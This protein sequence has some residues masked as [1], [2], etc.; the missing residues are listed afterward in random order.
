[1]KYLTKALWSLVF[2]LPAV[3]F[4]SYHPIIRLGSNESMNF[5]LSL[6]LIWLVI[7]DVLAFVVMIWQGYELRKNNRGQNEKTNKKSEKTHQ[8]SANHIPKTAKLPRTSW[9]INF[10]GIS[11]RKIFLLALFPL[12]ATISIFWSM[13]PVRA[14]LT[15]GII[16]LVFFAVFALI[17][18]LPLIEPIKNFSRK[19]IKAILIPSMAVCGFCWLQCFLDIMGVGREQSLLC[20][21]CVSDMFGF[22]HPSGFAI[23]PQFMGNLLLAPTLLAIYLAVFP[24][25]YSSNKPF[26]WAAAAI[27]SSTLFI[28]F[29]RGAIY[30]YLVALAIMF[31]FAIVQHKSHP[32]T[33]KPSKSPQVSGASRSAANIYPK[34]HSQTISCPKSNFITQPSATDAQRGPR[35]CLLVLVSTITFIFAL[36]MQG[37]FAELGPTNTSFSTAITRSVHHLSLGLI[38]LRPAKTSQDYQ[39]TH[40]S[41]QN[42]QNSSSNNPQTSNLDSQNTPESTSE[43]SESPVDS[44]P[45]SDQAQ[46][47]TSLNEPTEGQNQPVFDGYVAESTNVRLNLN[48]IAFETWLSAPGHPAAFWIGY[49]CHTPG[50]PC[51]SSIQV[52]PTSVLFGVGLGG[53]GTAM[54][55]AHPD[56]IASPKEIVQNQTFSLLLELGAVGIFLAHL[57]LV[58]A[59]L[60][61]LLPWWFVDGKAGKKRPSSQ[62][63]GQ[64]I[65]RRTISKLREN[66]FW[67]SPALPL[68]LSLVIAYIVTLN[69]FSGLPNALQIYLMPPLLLI[70]FRHNSTKIAKNS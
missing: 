26:I 34:S 56:E 23:E 60:A 11:D 20:R 18:V 51:N 31:I 15:A 32:K 48:E 47:E 42:S 10:P 49:D 21:G 33:L 25:K 28:T 41:A 43:A 24:Q 1:M 14:I 8:K 57:A 65:I 22:P 67:S 52:T 50:E 55:V 46:A 39:K 30:A 54:H 13:N 3:L 5:E 36:V 64:G 61:P 2:V 4:F 62:Y 66:D 45:L 7:F 69:F 44:E 17:F 68:L 40:D 63:R 38:D 9:G 19:M 29:S 70:V 6:P 12:F 35:F 16:W 27:C 53:A 59:F 58:V 37:I